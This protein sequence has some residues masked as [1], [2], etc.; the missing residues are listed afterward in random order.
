MLTTEL[1]VK[2]LC[3][4]NV[5]YFLRDKVLSVIQCPGVV[6]WLQSSQLVDATNKILG[7]STKNRQTELA[8]T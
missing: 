1:S 4:N 3:S 5:D 8:H 7:L 6:R 2:V